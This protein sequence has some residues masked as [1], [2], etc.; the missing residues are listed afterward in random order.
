[1]KLMINNNMIRLMAVGIV[2]LLLY[3]CYEDTPIGDPLPIEPDYTLP[4]GN[5]SQT[6]NDRIQ[7]IYD[8]YG[9]YILYNFTQKDFEWT[10]ASGSANSAQIIGT[11]ENPE[12]VEAMLNLLD[13][14][15]IGLFPD[16]FMKGAGLPYRVFL[17]DSIQ[18]LRVP[19]VYNPA[20]RQGLYYAY[21]ITGMSLAFTTLSEDLRTLDDAGKQTMRDRIQATVWRYYFEKEI[22]DFINLPERWDELSDYSTTV[23]VAAAPGRGFIP[24]M[25]LSTSSSAFMLTAPIVFNVTASNWFQSSTTRNKKNDVFAYI[26]QLTQKTTE[27][28]QPLIV[29]DIIQEKFEIIQKYF[30]DTYSIDLAAIGNFR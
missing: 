21:K 26:T 17:T 16:E 5:A 23:T 1:M 11:P 30:R 28:I 2:G 12:Y 22:F 25:T 24:Q 3:S 27:E 10:I 14:Y 7:Q 6:A 20:Q 19:G 13:K 9:S 29:N 8:T 18:S 15:W 4:Q